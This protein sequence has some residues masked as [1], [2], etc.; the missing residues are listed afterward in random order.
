MNSKQYNYWNY[1]PPNHFKN[2]LHQYHTCISLTN[3]TAKCITCTY[4]D[5]DKSHILFNLKLFHLRIILLIVVICCSMRNKFL[6]KP[7]IKMLSQ[8][9]NWISNV[10][11]YWY[12]KLTVPCEWVGV[13]IC[14]TFVICHHIL[15]HHHPKLFSTHIS[16]ASGVIFP[17]FDAF[18]IIMILC[19]HLLS[20]TKYPPPLY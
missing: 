2:I 13:L 10:W 18:L 17:S 8:S 5:Y 16:T 20:H 1:Q 3:T 9:S 7:K 15:C 11:I 19:F 12:L 14:F 4:I 6:L